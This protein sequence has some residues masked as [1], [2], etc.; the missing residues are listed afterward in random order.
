MFFHATFLGSY[1]EFVEVAADVL[2]LPAVL[3]LV[4]LLLVSDMPY[5]R[6]GL[7]SFAQHGMCCALC[8][9]WCQD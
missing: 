7:P 6:L 2:R 1:R 8:Y 5:L 4:L 3:G 9:S